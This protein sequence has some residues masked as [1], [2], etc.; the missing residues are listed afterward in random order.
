MRIPVLNIFILS[1]QILSD[2]T[3]A[4]GL[5]ANCHRAIASLFP[6]FWGVYLDAL[7]CSVIVWWWTSSRTAPAHANGVPVYQARSV[8]GGGRVTV[9]DW[10]VEWQFVD[11]YVVTD[12]PSDWVT[13]WLNDSVTEWL[14]DWVTEGPNDQMTKLPSDMSYCATY[15]KKLPKD[16]VTELPSDQVT[17]FE[18]TCYHV[19]VWTNYWATELLT[20]TLS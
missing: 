7:C 6:E 17:C 8:R 12:W 11:C 18:W 14:S 20:K 13:E 5:F 4:L 15:V 1:F 9:T 3:K 2:K 10:I 19:T 16:W